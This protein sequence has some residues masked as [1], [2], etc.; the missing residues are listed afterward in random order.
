MRLICVAV[1]AAFSLFSITFAA[2]AQRCGDADN[3]CSVES[4][5]YHMAMPAAG[6]AKGIVVHLHGAGAQARG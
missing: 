6:V 3:P 2:S 4:G 5:T 1:M